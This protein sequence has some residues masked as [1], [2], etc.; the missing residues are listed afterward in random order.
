ML[1]VLTYRSDQVHRDRPLRI[2][3]GDM[4]RAGGVTRLE[5]TPFSRETVGEL[6][7]RAA[8]DGDELFER[9]A[10][11]PFF[12]T[13]TLAAGTTALPETVREAV[14]AR[15]ARLS[16]DA[17]A[18]LDAVAVVPQRAEVWLLEA[19]SE[20]A[21]GALEDC[22]RSGVLRAEADGVMFRHELARLAIE[23][24]L[25]PDRAVTLHRLA[26][27]ALADP[28]LGTADLARLAHHAEAAGDGPAVLRYASAAGERAM[29][30]G[31][32]REAQHHYWRALRFAAG[33]APEARVELLE[34]FADHAY[35]SDMR[36]EAVQA[37]DEAIAIHRRAGNV[38]GEG[39]ALRRRA[40]LLSCI[41]RGQEALEVAREAVTVLEEA[42]RG[43]ELA[44]AYSALAGMSMLTYVRR[45]RWNGERRRSPWP[46]RSAIARRSSMR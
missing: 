18:L 46:M 24:S 42:P 35:L 16:P 44:R 43:A 23:A 25:P 5:L 4:P 41:G 31:S 40:R 10:G 7:S 34:R 6:A 12:V 22:L 26:L 2:V 29:A 15:V 19:L 20:G 27:D 33:I 3:L 39:D 36:A 9:T 30:L 17:R 11:N 45:P 28:T 21:L 37:I 32:P 13:E 38:L 1:L 8:V 14:H